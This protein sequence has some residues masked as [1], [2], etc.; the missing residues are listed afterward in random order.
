M[1]TQSGNQNDPPISTEARIRTMRI[2]WVALLVSIGNFYV[3]TIWQS[4]SGEVVPNQTLSISLLGGAVL[5]VLASF[6]IKGKLLSRAIE[7][8]QTGMVQQAYVV[9]WAVNEVAALLG[10]FDHFSTGNRYYYVQILI[11]ACGL[12]LHFPRREHVMNA[13]FQNTF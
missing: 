1:R 8:R 13:A 2:L 7:Q 11:A 5:A 10:V 6:V 12:L 4:R 3:L 9:A